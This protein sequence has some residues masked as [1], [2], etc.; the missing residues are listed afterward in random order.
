MKSLKTDTDFQTKLGGNG[1][2]F[3]QL[4]SEEW[5]KLSPEKKRPFE[6]QHEQ[7]KRQHQAYLQELVEYKQK[8]KDRQNAKGT[9]SDD[10]EYLMLPEEELQAKSKYPPLCL[11]LV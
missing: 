10:D 11:I 8:L 4:A 3:L 1:L 7:L 2:K 5:N 6:V 9:N